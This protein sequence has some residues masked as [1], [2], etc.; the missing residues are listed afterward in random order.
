MRS[1][2]H[3]EGL[4]DELRPQPRT[5]APGPRTQSILCNALA[6]DVLAALPNAV[7]TSEGGT[8]LSQATEGGPVDILCLGSGPMEEVL[9]DFGLGPLAVAFRPAD[10]SFCDPTNQLEAMSQGRLELASRH[11]AP[12]ARAPRR[13]WITARLSAEYDLKPT[14]EVLESARASFDEIKKRLP[15]GAPARREITRILASQDPT[16]GLAFLHEAGVTAYAAPGAQ[17]LQAAR[18][19]RLPTLLA[20][21]WAAWLRGSAT[22]SGLVRFRVPHRLARRIEHLQALHPLDRSIESSRDVSIRR[23]LSRT[24]LEERE[25]LFAWRRLEAA[26]LDNQVEADAI[27]ERLGKIESRIAAM[28]ANDTRAGQVRTLALDGSAVMALLSA[29]PGRHVGNAL[30]HLARFVEGDPDRNEQD[31]LE[32]ELRRWAEANTNLLD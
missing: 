13:Y 28:Q 4:L 3:G 22:A 11:P 2:S 29:G 16:A 8:R 30:A 23:I 9:L 27:Q 25:A 26:E 18:I 20:L 10:L 6:A 19:A 24:S 7:V 31:L 15:L 5:D 1:F 32:T 21:R 17:P 12:F 14:Q